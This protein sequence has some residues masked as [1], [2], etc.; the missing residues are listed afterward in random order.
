MNEYPVAGHAYR[1]GKLDA[2]AQFHVARRIMP[3]FADSAPMIISLVRAAKSGQKP[4]IEDLIKNLTPL[5]DALKNM[6]DEDADFVV[7]R[8]L[9]VVSRKME[10]GS[11]GWGPVIAPNFAL[12]YDDIAWPDLLQLVWLALK[13]NVLNFLADGR[14]NLSG[15]AS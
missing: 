10:I 5:A 2:R 11:Q 3:V 9:S 15:A 14:F 13:D 7:N 1:V 8:C 12:M 6:T 4:D